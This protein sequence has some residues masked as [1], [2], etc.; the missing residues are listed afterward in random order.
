MTGTMTGQGG[1]VHLEQS[2]MH[3]ALNIAKTA[4]EGILLARTEK[5]HQLIKKPRAEVREEKNGV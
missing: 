1:R 4:K 3:L 2:D 5:T